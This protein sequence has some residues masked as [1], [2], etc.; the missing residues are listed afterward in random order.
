MTFTLGRASLANLSGVHPDLVRVAHR[1]IELTTQDFGVFEGLR[2]AAR[3]AEYLKRG[4]T[5]TMKSKHLRQADGFGHAVDL[6]PYIDG[7]LRWEWG[8]IYPIAAAMQRAAQELGVTLTWG[9]V[10]DRRIGQLEVGATA[11]E[12]A[13]HAYSARH[14]GPD[15]LDGPHY[16]LDA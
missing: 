6:V 7:S 10:W 14:P 3:Q 16:Q 4:V 15:F 5:K 13:V 2:S 1:A 11:L 9:G 8:A 12:A